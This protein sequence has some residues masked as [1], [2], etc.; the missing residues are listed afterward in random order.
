MPEIPNISSALEAC[1]PS[2]YKDKKAGELEFD[3]GSSILTPPP[4]PGEEN[5]TANPVT[6]G[7]SGSSTSTSFSLVNPTNTTGS[8]DDVTN[9]SKGG[10]KTSKQPFPAPL[11]PDD[12][13][14]GSSSEG[15]ISQIAKGMA[16]VGG[17]CDIFCDPP[18]NKNGDPVSRIL[19]GDDV[20]KAVNSSSLEDGGAVDVEAF[21]NTIFDSIGGVPSS[22]QQYLELVQQSARVVTSDNQAQDAY[23]LSRQVLTSSVN[24]SHLTR[25]LNNSSGLVN[26][27]LTDSTSQQ[28][29]AEA[30]RFV[31]SE[32]TR[33]LPPNLVSAGYQIKDLIFNINSGNITPDQLVNSIS[34]ILGGITGRNEFALA[35]SVYNNVRGIVSSVQRGDYQALLSGQISGALAPFIGGENAAKVQAVMSTVLAGI[36][37]GKALSKLP[38]M[39][40]LMDGYEIPALEQAALILQCTDLFSQIM[41]LLGSIQ[42][43][44][45]AFKSDKDK[46]NR[47]N[48]TRSDYNPYNSR[49]F[50]DGGRGIGTYVTESL[51]RIIQVFNTVDTVRRQERQEF[52]EDPYITDILAE[53]T[54]INLDIGLSECFKLPTLTLSQSEI[55]II[56]V[57]QNRIYFSTVG[58]SYIPAEGDVIQYRIAYFD[59]VNTSNKLFPYQ[60]D[61]QYTPSVYNY[62]VANYNPVDNIGIAIF[63]PNSSSIILQRSDGVL[64]EF[65]PQAIGLRLKPFIIDSYVVA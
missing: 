29:R 26:A 53:I 52:I 1:I 62:R 41:A 54:G 46:E 18:G 21:D 47:D 19:I 5:S 63:T 4:V 22:V 59:D 24:N 20:G 56:R 44:I 55:N 34:S 15:A 10:G 23:T 17:A 13:K 37:A 61:V 51:P 31:L 64:I 45:N 14:A 3:L 58:S 38:E 11:T 25:V 30:E 32:V 48:P 16:N 60:N 12:S 65:I 8:G 27:L 42:G 57:E 35:A 7:G 43:L 36:N 33:Y 50:T 40:S 49:T 9:S 6:G 39:L 2:K 28:I